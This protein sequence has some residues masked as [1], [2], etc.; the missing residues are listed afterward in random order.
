[1]PFALQNVNEID[2]LRPRQVAH[3]C[4]KQVQ[5]RFRVLPVLFVIIPSEVARGSLHANLPQP[6]AVFGSATKFIGHFNVAGGVVFHKGA[7]VMWSRQHLACR[8]L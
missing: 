7:R 8:S 6:C 3:V 5:H 2:G 4:R 1:M